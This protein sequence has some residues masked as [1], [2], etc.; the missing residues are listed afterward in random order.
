[1]TEADTTKR[2]HGSRPNWVFVIGARPDSAPP[3]SHP[4]AILKGYEEWHVGYPS[5][6]RKPGTR[7]VGFLME[8]QNEFQLQRIDE[9]VDHATGMEFHRIPVTVETL[10][11]GHRIL[12][13]V[14]QRVGHASP[15]DLRHGVPPLYVEDDITAAWRAIS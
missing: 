10:H 5:I 4:C 11:E 7:T 13:W 9:R 14:Y 1:M 3:A 8:L 6:V 15:A 2:T 12:A